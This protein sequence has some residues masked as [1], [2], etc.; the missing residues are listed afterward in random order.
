MKSEHSNEKRSRGFTLLEVIVTLIV[1]SILGAMLVAFVGKSLSGSAQLP[2]RMVKVYE[3]NQIM[4]NISADYTSM[5]AQTND[6]LTVLKGRID[7]NTGNYGNYTPSTSWIKYT[8]SP[9]IETPGVA[10]DGILKVIISPPSGGAGL[11]HTGI[12]T[13]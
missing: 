10:S 4:D 3:M 1:A 8:G 2:Y 11:S 6:V 5:L 9:P 7:N 12:F 13:R